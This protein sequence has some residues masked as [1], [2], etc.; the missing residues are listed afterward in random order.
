[1]PVVA[2]PVKF[3]YSSTPRINHA[4]SQ[5]GVLGASQ[6]TLWKLID[7]FFFPFDFSISSLSLFCCTSASHLQ[8]AHHGCHGPVRLLGHCGHLSPGLHLLHIRHLL[9]QPYCLWHAISSCGPSRKHQK[10]CE[11]ISPVCRYGCHA[12]FHVARRAS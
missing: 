4:Q 8:V 7:C 12:T 2:L 10:S 1:M 9:C 6:G 5:P 11:S 3:P